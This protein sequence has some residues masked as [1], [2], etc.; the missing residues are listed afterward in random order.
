MSEI[1][2]LTPCITK[3]NTWQRDNLKKKKILISSLRVFQA[4]MEMKIQSQNRELSYLEFPFTPSASVL[5]ATCF[6]RLWK[7][8]N[9]N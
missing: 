6:F 8:K 2:K 3:N 9:R 1:E 5:Q 4:I 7:A